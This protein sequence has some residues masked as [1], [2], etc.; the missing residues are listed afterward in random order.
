MTISEK[1]R[2]IHPSVT[3]AIDARAK[4]LRAMGLDVIG[5]GAGEP[6]FDTPRYIKS[7][8]RDAL[9]AG[10]TKYTPVAGTV[11]LRTEIQQKLLRDNGLDYELADIIVSSG[12]KQCLFNALSAIL[13]PGDEVLLPSPCWVSY[14]EMVR[15]AGGTPVFLYCPESQGFLPDMGDLEKLITPRTKAF[16]LNNPSNPNGC[17]W[18]REQLLKLGELAVKYDFYIISDEIYEKLVYDGLQHV[19]MASLGEDIKQH[20]ILINGVSKSYAM[21]G[22]RIGYALGPA[23]VIRG[24]ITYQSQATSGANTAA[25]HAAAVA[26]S[27]RQDYVEEMRQAFEQRRN[28]L[29]RLVNEIPGLHCN[30]PHG[31]FYVMMNIH[32]LIGK[33]YHGE[34]ITGSDRFSMLLLEKAHVAAVPG[35]AFMAEGYCRLSYATSMQN[36]QEGMRRIADFVSQLQ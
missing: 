16:V 36:I 23:D 4:Q 5:F 3:L 21:T 12:A 32:D 8:A 31:A 17:I 35:V 6:D 34:E 25:Q 7:A 15:M 33:R 29:V 11:E 20:T 19:C 14:P 18:T 10:M 24:M 9:D 26:L 27:M 30:M 28:E 22:F 13:D 2:N 1:C